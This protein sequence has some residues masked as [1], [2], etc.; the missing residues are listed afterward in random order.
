MSTKRN[1][2]HTKYVAYLTPSDGIAVCN[3]R[4]SCCDTADPSEFSMHEV[5]VQRSFPV[6]TVCARVCVHHKS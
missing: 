2:R 4:K 6:L 1:K 5:I 3:V